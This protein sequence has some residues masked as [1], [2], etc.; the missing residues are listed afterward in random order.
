MGFG[1]SS[2]S[3]RTTYGDYAFAGAACIARIF[4]PLVHVS[5]DGDCR[6]SDFSP[7]CELSGDLNWESLLDW[8]RGDG[9]F[10]VPWRPAGGR[11]RRLTI[12]RLTGVLQGV[13]GTAQGWHFRPFPELVACGDDDAPRVVCLADFAQAWEEQPLPG[14]LDLPGRVSLDAPPYAD[15]IV[16]S[17]PTTMIPLAQDAGLDVVRVAASRP[18]PTMDW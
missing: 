1:Q 10:D 11:A 13:A 4:L 2:M 9:P 14:R 3:A 17:G 15:S 6:W 12:A 18:L 7:G 8:G 5:G 16:L